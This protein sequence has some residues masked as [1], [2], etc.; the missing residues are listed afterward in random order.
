MKIKW[1]ALIYTIMMLFM[2]KFMI[3]SFGQDD[4]SR[5]DM[6]Y[7]ND[8]TE[9]IKNAYN[10]GMSI[11]DIEKK[12][13]C[14]IV[15]EN[16]SDYMAKIYD[17]YA[18]YGL[19]MDF[20]EE[21]ATGKICLSSEQS[22]FTAAK[23]N[24]RK[25]SIYVWGVLLAAG[26][27]LMYVIYHYYIRPFHELQH[28]T[29]DIAKGN[30]D[31]FLPIHKANIFGAF[32]ESFDVMREELAAS[33]MREAKAEKSKKELVAQL[34]HDI[35][36]PVA[37]IKA[38]CEVLELQEKM[39]IDE[40][41]S[42][43]EKKRIESS[44]EKIGYITNKAD[45]IDELI[46]NMFQ[47]T[48]EELNELEVKPVE[49]D[50]RVISDF[51]NELSAFRNIIIENEL[52]ECLV[53]MDKLRMEQVIGNIIGNSAKY[54][55][56][57]ISVTYKDGFEIDSRTKEKF[58]CITIRDY[59]KGISDEDVYNVAEKFYRGQ[60]AAGKQGSGLGLY[61]AKHFMEMQMGGFECYNHKSADNEND[62]FV[63]ELYLKKV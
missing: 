9:Q 1:I 59:G 31:A 47:A 14:E 38:T 52:P 22:A 4:F 63:T 30:L 35:K 40:H 19:V 53:Y 8:I 41:M 23:D 12:Y 24:V 29:T 5:R 51:F 43:T 56:T 62:G 33:R 55:G 16:D 25:N 50:S 48:L 18:D 13:K 54:A 58:L 3:G 42:D 6:V 2:L 39:R 20:H 11:E 34:S 7:Y 45:T 44:L 15:L 61:L 27:I 46:N 36:T 32:T 60:N 17:Y 21:D 10:E 37:T 26:Y 28:F 49:T 57:D